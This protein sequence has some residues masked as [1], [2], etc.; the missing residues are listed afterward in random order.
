MVIQ[1]L[2]GTS[3]K[4]P[5]SR[6]LGRG[7]VVFFLVL[8]LATVHFASASSVLLLLFALNLIG[9]GAYLLLH[10]VIIVP[11]RRILD[12]MHHLELA[13]QEV[14]ERKHSLS[15]KD[16]I[17]D[18]QM[19]LQ[20]LLA[21]YHKHQKIEQQLAEAHKALSHF[22]TEQGIITHAASGEITQQY[23]AI[24]AYA[25]YLEERIAQRSADPSLREDYDE[26]CEQAFNLQLIVQAMGVLETT[27]HE[28]PVLTRVSL[29]ERI[30]SLM[31][32]LTPSLDR[33]AMKLTTLSWNETV[34]ARSHSELL[35][36]TLWMLLIGGF[37]FA[38][39]ESTL[40][41]G[42]TEYDGMAIMEITISFLSPA[43]LTESER[44]AYLEEK[45]RSGGRD[46]S[47]F[48]QALKEHGNMQLA[49]LLAGRIG[50][51]V[52]ITPITSYS[53]TIALTLPRA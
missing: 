36:L 49:Q 16:A 15:L 41:L 7:L 23:R 52:T 24:L 2:A 12:L 18:A 45:L 8:N 53:C 39:D 42:C 44:L 1:H 31:L 33:R 47:M 37:R 14:A 48:A 11:I 43:A 51:Q 19:R 17:Y 22:Y 40:T 35:T 20:T 13:G 5:S 29:S 50:A 30:I 32:D 25:H 4:I 21:A 10:R 3:L 34:H 46:A 26:V 6:F 9:L 27:R 28:P 38:V